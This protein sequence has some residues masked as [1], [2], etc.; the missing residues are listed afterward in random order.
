MDVKKLN[1]V[2]AEMDDLPETMGEMNLNKSAAN[3]RR[4][5]ATF[6]VTP[7][8]LDKRRRGLMRPCTIDGITIYESKQALTAALGSGQHGLRHPNFRFMNGGGPP[9]PKSRKPPKE[10]VLKVPKPPKEPKPRPKKIQH[11]NRKL[12]TVDDGVTVYRCG[13]DMIKAIGQGIT[14]SRSPSFRYLTDEEVEKYWSTQPK[15]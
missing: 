14:G 4:S 8:T 9:K 11:G 6:L 1:Q 7:E 10:P 3:R 2:L 12:C 5:S 15:A 13:M